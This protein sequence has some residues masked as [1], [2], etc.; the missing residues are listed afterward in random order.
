ML[1]TMERTE[2]IVVSQLRAGNEEAFH[3]LYRHHYT[4]LCHVAY[5]YVKDR[6]L[7]ESLVSDVMF[8]LW[9][10]H[11]SLEIEVSLR[12]YL[13]T[14]VRHHC[15]NYLASKTERTE[16]AFSALEQGERLAERAY[17]SEEQPMGRLLE[18][19]LEGEIRKA[20][21]ALPQECRSV[22]LKSRFEEKKYEEI[23]QELNIS[24]NT[25][26]YH[27]KNALVKLTA[28][29]EKYLYITLIIFLPLH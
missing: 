29:L 1:P 16:I 3:Y 13:I 18:K 6:F 21:A 28:Q 5:E 27:I 17:D 4:M 23:A 10:I 22:F 14:A 11:E 20:I 8:H 12:S 26:K 19:E 7:A 15:L 2:Q 9:E 25:V 24:V